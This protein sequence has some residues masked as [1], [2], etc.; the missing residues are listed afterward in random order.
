[1]INSI[2]T[3]INSNKFE[4]VIILLDKHNHPI[5]D[6]NNNIITIEPEEIKLL[7]YA[8]SF[9]DDAIQNPSIESRTRF[10]WS[11]FR[12]I[13]YNLIIISCFG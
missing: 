12:C 1:M 11:S 8:R 2:K 3:D 4:P 7:N 9:I 13:S 10:T 5:R 6:K